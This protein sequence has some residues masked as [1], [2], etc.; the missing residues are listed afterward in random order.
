M[1][2]GL[3]DQT[4]GK[5]SISKQE[6]YQEIHISTATVVGSWQKYNKCARREGE[7]VEMEK[8]NLTTN[9]NC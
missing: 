4:L 1:E 5:G 8:L 3:I 7:R 2:N 9:F 6:K